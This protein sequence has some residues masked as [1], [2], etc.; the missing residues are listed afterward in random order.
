MP[1]RPE[2][3]DWTSSYHLAVVLLPEG[4]DRDAVRE[5]LAERGVQTSVH[6]PPIHGFTAYS[7]GARALPKTDAVAER[8]LTLPLY[9]RLTEEQVEAVVE[10]LPAAS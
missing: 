8:L 5:A 1:F 2:G 3:E 6:Y 7:D 4:S 10:G 9:G